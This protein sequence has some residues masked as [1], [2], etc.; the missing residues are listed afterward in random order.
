MRFSFPSACLG[1][2]VKKEVILIRRLMVAALK[3]EFQGRVEKFAFWKGRG[4][5][6][7]AEP[8]LSI[9]SR[10]EEEAWNRAKGLTM[11]Q[12]L[13]EVGI[14]FGLRLGSWVP[15]RLGSAYDDFR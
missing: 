8:L 12:F 5:R 15:S 14:G 13:D 3:T 10:N 6:S 1:A 4:P 9:L 11:P 2:L 7:L